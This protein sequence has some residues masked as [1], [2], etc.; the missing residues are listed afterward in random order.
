MALVS[1]EFNRRWAGGR[2]V[3][4][5]SPT[6]V[7]RIRQGKFVRGFEGWPGSPVGA[8]IPGETASKPWQARWVALTPWKELPNTIECRIEQDLTANGIAQA[9]ISLENVLMRDMN[10]MGMLYHLIDRGALAPYRG[11][12]APNFTP[13]QIPANEWFDTI[14]KN[15]QVW[16]Q[17]GYGPDTMTHVFTGLID[18][19]DP[20]S[21]GKLNI[22]ARDFG[23]VLVE[24]RLFGW[25]DGPKVIDPVI[26]TAKK[27]YKRG[28]SDPV[29]YDASASSTRDG[30]PARFVTVVDK[31]SRWISQDHSDEGVTEWVQVRLPKGRYESFHIHPGY[32]GMEVY[33]GIYARDELL[34]GESA[35]MDEVNIK[36][37]WVTVPEDEGGGV[38]PGIHG[39]WPYIKKWA[40]MT[41]AKKSYPLDHNLELGNNSILRVGFRKLKNVGNGKYRASCIRLAGNRQKSERKLILRLVAKEADASSHRTGYGPSQVIDES[42]ATPWISQDHTSPDVT[43]WVSIRVPQGRYDSFQ[44]HTDYEDMEMYVG[45]YARNRR[46]KKSKGKGYEAVPCQVDDEDLPLD[47]NGQW[48][49]LL[50]EADQPY[51]DV[52]GTHGGWPYIRYFTKV[53]PQPKGKPEK[54]SFGHKLELGDDSV[55]RVG[56]RD[57]HRINSGVYRAS[58]NKLKAYTRTGVKQ[59][60][61]PAPEIKKIEVDDPSDIVRCVLRWAGFKEWEVENTGAKLK[62]DWIFNRQTYLADVIKKVGEAT[63]FIFYIGAPSDDDLSI[64]VPVFRSSYLL[65][66]DLEF[67]TV[68]DTDLL[69]GVQARFTEEP[70]GYIIRVR[71][72]IAKKGG[73]Q[74]GSD[75]T[76]RYMSVYRPPWHPRMAGVIKHVVHEMRRLQDQLSVEVAARLIAVQ[77]ALA[78][79]TATIETPGNPGFELDGQLGL[80]D[81]GTGLKTRLYVARVASTFSRGKSTKWVTTVGGSLLDTPDITEAKRELFTLVPSGTGIPVIGD[82][83]ES[84][85]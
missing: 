73:K 18:D 35:E 53:G 54:F 38:V 25:V 32:P 37:G 63:G 64:G 69:T 29:G 15:A 78:S 74:L 10:N 11:Y 20:V 19:V 84:D 41:D 34:G 65:R 70:L 82:E 52:P 61:P 60:E 62:G 26:F 76:A 67:G 77:Q 28:P 16:I 79:A 46:R 33:V 58:V 45:V 44:I 9:N 43:E 3:G 42:T 48:I 12:N 31:E 50:D 49:R 1:D 81:T 80:W 14:V 24:E 36:N 8:K 83:V 56:F 57:L 21:P 68:R 27:P 4:G 55:I 22:V 51:P 7:I 13:W 47:E 2:H 85:E 40:R 6:Q 59:P 23:K 30:Y 66:D 17:Q 39:G 5:Y 71:G 72:D 75:K